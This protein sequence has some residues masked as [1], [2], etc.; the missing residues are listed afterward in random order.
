MCCVTSSFNPSPIQCVWN[1]AR[2][3][4]HYATIRLHIIEMVKHVIFLPSTY[5]DKNETCTIHL[6]RHLTPHLQ[7]ATHCNIFRCQPPPLLNMINNM[8]H[9]VSQNLRR[10]TSIRYNSSSLHDKFPAPPNLITQLN[11]VME[12]V[13]P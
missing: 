1:S 11:N 3:L 4:L 2:M 12:F 10:Q 6:E 5:V 13:P 7:V 9:G 8:V